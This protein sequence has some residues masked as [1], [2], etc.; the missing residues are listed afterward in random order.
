MGFFDTLVVDEQHKYQID[1]HVLF[2]F[3]VMYFTT[4]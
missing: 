2:I 1:K 4:E 3:G